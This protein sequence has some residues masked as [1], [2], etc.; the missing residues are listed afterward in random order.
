MFVLFLLTSSRRH[1]LHQLRGTCNKS[2]M[3]MGTMCGNIRKHGISRT[4]VFMAVSALCGSSAA[5]LR[6]TPAPCLNVTAFLSF[7][8]LVVN[9]SRLCKVLDSV[10]LLE[11][12]ER[13]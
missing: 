2:L 13:D 11:G 5:D 6:W 1:L 8:G 9:L 10:W 7:K 3:E 4:M 12:F